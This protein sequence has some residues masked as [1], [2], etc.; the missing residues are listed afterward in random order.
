LS[1]RSCETYSSSI[2]NNYNSRCGINCDYNYTSL[3][4]S[5][6]TIAVISSAASVQRH[7]TTAFIDEAVTASTIAAATTITPI[8]VSTTAEVLG[9]T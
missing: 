2:S 8:T 4:T 9:T 7:K 1:I 6:T 3:S 5:I